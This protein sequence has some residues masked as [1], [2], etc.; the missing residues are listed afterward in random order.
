M[1]NYHYTDG[2]N[3]FGPFSIEELKLKSI[4]PDTLVWTEGM[5]TWIKAIDVPELKG[6]LSFEN[7]PPAL[8]TN[9]PEP[10]QAT[11]NSFEYSRPPKTYLIETILSTIF[12]CWPVGIVSIVYAA[13]VE[14]KFYAGDKIGAEED[15][16]NA[17]KWM[18]I[19]IIAAIVLYIA[20][21][22]IFGLAMLGGALN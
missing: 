21:F 18:I 15:S 19:N 10:H 4:S 9:S 16:A 13:R 7:T 3:S 8:P 2:T 22:G 17:K 5:S 20:Y 11:N 12:C 14:K 6:E 1:K